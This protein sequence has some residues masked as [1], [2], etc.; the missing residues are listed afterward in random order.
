MARIPSRQVLPSGAVPT[1]RIPSDIADT[2]QELEARGLGDLGAGIGAV[3]G[4]LLEIE[5][6]KIQANDIE[7]SVKAS[8]GRQKIK[9][10]Q[11]QFELDNKFSTEFWDAAR[12]AR[13]SQFDDD[14]GKLTFSEQARTKQDLIHAAEKQHDIAVGKLRTSGVTVDNSITSSGAA[15]ITSASVGALDA[16]ELRLQHKEALSLKHTPT[17]VE[18]LLR[19]ADFEVE[20]NKIANLISVG[21]FEE[22]KELAK[23]TK[24]FTPQ[25]REATLSSI[26]R[27]QRANKT[28]NENLF[29]ESAAKVEPGWLQRLRDGDLTLEGEIENWTYG[30]TD[31][32]MLRKQVDLQE[33]WLKKLDSKV[34]TDQ[35]SDIYTAW[36]A[37]VD[38]APTTPVGDK[39]L[40]E[41]IYAQVGPDRTK[42]LSIKEAEH[43][44]TKLEGNLSN[45]N[46]INQSFHT[47]Y[48][49]LLTGQFNTGMFGK[50]K[51]TGNA[52][53]T[54]NR[55]ALQLTQFSNENQTASNKEWKEM[56]DSLSEQEQ[57]PGFLLRTLSTAR[58]RGET[59][60][61]P[62]TFGFLP[63]PFQ[64]SSFISDVRDSK[65][66]EIPDS[67]P[68]V[69]S[70][71]V[72]D[73]QATADGSVYIMIKKGAT[74]AE[75]V[76]QLTQ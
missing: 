61:L 47:R 7:Q 73:T 42:N 76:W 22:A 33:E 17:T 39:P 23:S 50:P 71:K 52:R 60:P 20:K 65:F 40:R 35:T 63:N 24:A 13:W 10:D 64:I 28:Q 37:K 68:D 4:V 25:E 8:A 67:A 12:E 15:Y 18:I 5:I 46:T 6:R 36:V 11:N 21:G 57:E 75:D 2:G 49:R 14:F 45:I 53:E 31:P 32:E 59:F 43:L 74:P 58:K 51:K 3:G 70:F 27:A 9:D 38:L 54:Y 69:S 1:A 56:F 29:N 44:V 30:G 34:M 55:M 66:K 26:N 19:E 41:A 16:P 48:Q 62:G 72:G